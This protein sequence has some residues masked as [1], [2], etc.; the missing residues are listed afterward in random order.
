M[1]YLFIM[2]ML[3]SWHVSG[4]VD[5]EQKIIVID[6]AETLV[7]ITNRGDRTEFIQLSLAQ[8]INPGVPVED[9]KRVPLTDIASPVIYAFPLKMTLQP[10]QSKPVFLR[11]LKSV[12]QEE[13]YRLIVAPKIRLKKTPDEDV[14]TGVVLNIGY[15]ALVRLLPEQR[16]ESFSVVCLADGG[17]IKATG[18]VRYSMKE[19]YIAGQPVAH[20]NVYPD[21]PHPFKGK[22]LRYKNKD[23]CL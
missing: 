14:G 21:V 15:Q 11:R 18:N 16:Q 9:E 6:K 10:G 3:A 17:E 7:T 8:L 5:L 20:F 13:V 2:L 4:Y 12:T 1:K 22:P 23:Y 19:M